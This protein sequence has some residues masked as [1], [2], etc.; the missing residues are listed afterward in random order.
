M[1]LRPKSPA[2]AGRCRTVILILICFSLVQLL[3]DARCNYSQAFN[4]Y[5]TKETR[6]QLTKFQNNLPPWR[7]CPTVRSGCVLNQRPGTVALHQCEAHSQHMQTLDVSSNTVDII[8][9]SWA[10]M[11]NEEHKSQ[12]SVEF[13][14]FLKTTAW[15]KPQLWS[16]I[17]SFTIVTKSTNIKTSLLS[18][19]PAS[20]I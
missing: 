2:W 12:T 3:N 4:H 14:M 10:R 13:H 16:S 5:L 18:S 15:I 1:E 19:H 9:F 8:W 11:H 7:W 17:G 20:K 6:E